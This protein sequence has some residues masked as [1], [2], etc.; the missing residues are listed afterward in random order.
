[1]ARL[2]VQYLNDLP[3]HWIRFT[4]KTFNDIVQA[5]FDLIVTEVS[6]GINSLHLLSLVDPNASW[7]Q[8]WMVGHTGRTRII[9]YMQ[10]RNLISYFATCYV[11]FSMTGHAPD[12]MQ[13]GHWMD[14][15]FAFADVEYLRFL[16][17]IVILSKLLSVSV[18][19][20]CFPI[21]IHSAKLSNLQLLTV[22]H[23]LQLLVHQLYSK[24]TVS[25][26]HDLIA[27]NEL[28][29]CRFTS[30]V[31]C[32]LISSS[33]ECLEILGMVRWFHLAWVCRSIINRFKI[34]QGRR[35]IVY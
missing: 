29:L 14:A 12:E 27:E 34:N 15:S 25:T 21:A 9:K 28:R 7:F 16:N 20:Q 31:I 10:K 23:F 8:K 33:R 35:N 13:R 2:A 6:S 32:D 18:G 5:T 30:K 4:E 11:E 3:S 22:N 26:D 24:T 17:I 1:M 19:R